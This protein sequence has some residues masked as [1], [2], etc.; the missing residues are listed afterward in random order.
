MTATPS[1]IAAEMRVSA[2]PRGVSDIADSLIDLFARLRAVLEEETAA[3]RERDFGLV[4][5]L[6]ERKARL[7]DAYGSDV[8]ALL[9]AQKNGGGLEPRLGARLRAAAHGFLTSLEMNARTLSGSKVAHE[10]F[11]KVISDAVAAKARPAAGYSKT[12]AY[13]NIDQ[14][15]QRRTVPIALN[16]RV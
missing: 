3:V 14:R 8:R 7:A 16:E 15:G 4:E 5:A 11:V 2:R 1:A 9:E 6:A 10:Q 13:G 12:G